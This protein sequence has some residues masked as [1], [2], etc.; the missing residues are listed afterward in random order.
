MG[1]FS[2]LFGNDGKRCDRCGKSIKPSPLF[3]TITTPRIDMWTLGN[4]AGYCRG[5]R[6]YLCSQHLEF[7]N[8]GLGDDIT[9]RVACANCGTAITTGP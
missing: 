1:I 5:C 6:K 9:Y 8:A 2:K 7:R 3:G 4:M